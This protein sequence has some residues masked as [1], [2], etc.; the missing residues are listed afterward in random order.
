MKRDFR[1]TERL[2]IEC[3][4]TVGCKGCEARVKGSGVKPHSISAEDVQ[5]RQSK[6]ETTRA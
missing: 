5:R 4:V 2:L 6:N 3:G 1:I